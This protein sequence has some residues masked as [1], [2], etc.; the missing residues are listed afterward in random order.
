MIGFG[1]CGGSLRAGSLLLLLLAS[2]C[3]DSLP[4]IAGDLGGRDAT[5]DSRPP[6]ADRGIIPTDAGPTQDAAPTDAGPTQDAAPTD[7]GPTQD[8]APT[9]TTSPVDAPSDL[10]TT[11][12][13]PCDVD[14]GNPQNSADHVV[15]VTVNL[16]SSGNWSDPDK[17][18]WSCN[19]GYCED[20]NACLAS[21]SVQC[22]MNNANPGNSSDTLANVNIAC[23]SD[24]TFAAP[25]PCE[26]S[27][28]SGYCEDGNT[29]LASMSVQCDMNNAN[30]GNSSDTLANV[31]IACQSDGTFA[32]PAP[33][34]WSCNSGYC[35][36][37]N[38]CLASTSVQC[39]TNNANPGN[40]SDTLANVNVACQS[41][42]TFA[43][44]TPCEWSCNSGYCEDG[45]TCLASTSVQCNTNNANPTNSSDTLANVNVACQSDGTF[46]APTA[47]EWSCNTNL[48]RNV[49]ATACVPPIYL[50]DAGGG[51]PGGDRAM[52][53]TRCADAVRASFAS[54]D[55]SGNGVGLISISASDEIRDL[56]STQGIPTDR[57]ILGPTTT[58]IVDSWADL[59]DESVDT[60]LSAASV[61]NSYWYSGS[62]SDGSLSSCSYPWACCGT[63][64]TGTCSGW[65]ATSGNDGTYGTPTAT[66]ARWLS[67]HFSGGCGGAYHYLCL[68]WNLLV[69]GQFQSNVAN[70]TSTT[71]PTWSTADAD[72]SANSGSIQVYNNNTVSVNNV[73]GAYQCVPTTGGKNLTVSARYYIPSGQPAT[74]GAGFNV[75]TFANSTCTGTATGVFNAIYSTTTNA[76]TAKSLSFTTA[77]GT[78]SLRIRLD[79]QKPASTGPVHIR[80]DNVLLK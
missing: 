67:T 3:N 47:C 42:G 60:S 57:P 75:V 37:G 74:P 11:K 8:A 29:C 13:V 56:P 63:C 16:V 15:D 9:E 10:T 50:L 33:C 6:A 7:A 27:C 53:N 69:N 46:T 36:D 52:M 1:N 61:T 14:N 26:W 39:N 31:N 49:S 51:T 77:S 48:Y 55:T 30:P 18:E 59:L 24:G 40:S 19:S 65:T 62:L 17:C 20:G 21:M 2:A 35:E 45:N 41:D 72:D 12:Q 64:I 68:S 32:A 54:L 76:W 4:P 70:W 22:D 25:A 80:Y 34:K 66:N 79:V 78:N 58:K 5:S 38:T 44:P 73:T 71:T 43:A 23:Q 28:N